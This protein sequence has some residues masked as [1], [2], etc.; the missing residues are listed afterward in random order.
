MGLL[1]AFGSLS[2]VL[3]PIFVSYIYTHYG[4]Y[5]TVLSMVV[6]LLIS[7]VITIVFYKRLLPLELASAQPRR[8]SVNLD[9]TEN[10][11]L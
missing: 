1:S 11:Q 4:T 6:S 8:P 7:L 10:S 3:G 9:A 2:R 5:L